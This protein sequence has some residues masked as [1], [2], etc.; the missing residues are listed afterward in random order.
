MS[1]RFSREEAL[2]GA[3]KL[4]ILNNSKVAI[5]GVGGVGG[6]VA[7]ALAR[8]GVGAIDVIDKDVINLSNINRQIYALSSTVGKFK[9]EVAKER[10]K[11][12]FPDC[13]VNAYK[14][15]FLPENA[16][17]FDFSAYDYVIDAV[18]TVAAKLCIAE[19]AQK[20]GVKVISAMGAGNKLNAVGFA[21]S[22][23]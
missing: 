1:E 2:L 10:I 20:V 14:T 9:V 19:K 8:A 16:D 11:D 13:K 3:E 12:I 17:E 4:K 18:D 6:Y 22:D 21:V 7:E 5:F 15:F 23:I